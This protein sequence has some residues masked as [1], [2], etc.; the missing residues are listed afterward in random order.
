MFTS[1]SSTKN[2]GKTTIQMFGF[3]VVYIFTALTNTTFRLV[4]IFF[5]CYLFVLCIL[6]QQ[7]LVSEACI[8]C[9]NKTDHHRCWV[10]DTLSGSVYIHISILSP[11]DFMF[12]HVSVKNIN[13]LLP[14][15]WFQEISS[16]YYI[17]LSY[18]LVAISNRHM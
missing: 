2:L 1:H 9:C 14:V 5:L 8:D 13:S 10:S 6:Y 11:A 4:G 7:K 18:I 12:I 15:V 16:T 3:I 17:F